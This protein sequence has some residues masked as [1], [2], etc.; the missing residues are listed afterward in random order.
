[1]NAYRQ[2]FGSSLDVNAIRYADAKRRNDTAELQR[3]AATKG[4][5]VTDAQK[6]L[7]VLKSLAETGD[8][9]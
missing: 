1:V 7:R 9:P 8:M 3:L 6:R 2:A 4:F 5:N